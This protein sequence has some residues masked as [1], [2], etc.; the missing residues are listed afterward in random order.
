MLIFF[1]KVCYNIIIM[2]DIKFIKENKDIIKSS[3]VKKKITVDVDRLLELDSQRVELSSKIEE[4]RAEQNKVSQSISQLSETDKI[5]TLERMKLLKENMRI[6]DEKLTMVM[7]EWR[8]LMLA[9]P[10]IPD[11]SVPVGDS[12]EDNQEI[13]NWGEIRKFDFTPLPHHELMEK[14]GWADFERGSKTSGFRGYF[15]KGDAAMLEM[16]IWQYAMQRWQSKGFEPMIVPSLVK[17]MS[18]VGTGYLPGG[19][20]D[21]YHDGNEYFAGTGE[22]STMYYYSDEIIKFQN[23]KPIKMLAFSPCF[24]KEAGAHS[25]DV[26]GLIRV[27]EFFKV[28]QVVLCPASHELS[29]QLHEE[30]TRN[31]EEMMEELGLPYRVVVNCTGDLGQGQVKKYDIEAW[32]PSQNKYRETHSASYFHD[33]QTRRLNIRYRDEEDKVRF[34]H[35]LNNTA[36]ATP[37]LLAIIIEYYQNSDGSVTIPDILVPYMG[38]KNII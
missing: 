4:M 9:I 18:L 24:R 27:H 36:A 15:L 28:E 22:V 1:I 17:D 33:Y 25:K 13:R 35:S 26:K 11:I 7:K 21:L 10:N 37:R 6:E 12:D 3:A 14:R 2:L 30:I 19:E 20:Q 29:V 16:A 23:N 34:V 31:S 5:A 32:E 8:L 38:G